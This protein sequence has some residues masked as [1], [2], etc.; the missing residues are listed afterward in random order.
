MK[1]FLFFSMLIVIA[2]VFASCGEHV[3]QFGEWETTKEAT[4]EISGIQE[5]Y[6]SCGAFENKTIEAQ[7]DLYSFKYIGASCGE[8]YTESTCRKCNEVIIEEFTGSGDHTYIQDWWIEQEPDCETPGQAH[9][10]CCYCTE[11]EYKE[12]D[13]LGHLEVVDEAI[14]PTCDRIGLTQGSHCDR[15][16]KTLVQ[17]YTIS[18]LEHT[19]ESVVTEPTYQS[20]GYTTRTCTSCGYS[21][22]VDKTE[23]LKY[24]IIWKDWDETIL[25][26]DSVEYG[27][28][29]TYDTTPAK[30]ST[31]GYIY[32]FNGWDETVT[33][34]TSDA[35]YTAT[36]NSIKLYTITWENWDGTVLETNIVKHGEIPTYNGTTPTKPSTVEYIYEFNGWDE[37]VT[38]ATSDATYKAS[39]YSTTRKYCVTWQNWDGSTLDSYQFAYG[40]MPVYYGFTPTKLSTAE[41]SYEFSGWNNTLTV[42]TGDITYIA[43]YN[44]IKRQYT[45]TWKNWDGT[46]LKIDE[47]ISAGTIPTY[48]GATPTKNSDA[49]TI[50]T[51][52]GEWSSPLEPIYSNTIFTA[53]FAATKGTEINSSNWR[54]YFSINYKYSLKRSTYD[55]KYYSHINVYGQATNINS[56]YEY[57]NV[58]VTVSVTVQFYEIY[59]GGTG[60]RTKTEQFTFTINETGNS[61]FSFD[62]YDVY[63]MASGVNSFSMTLVDI[64]GYAIKK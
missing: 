31:D 39:F 57:V 21:Y 35:T 5:R 16:N 8:H 30:P 1:K 42:V 9:R 6:C 32:E 33:A 59:D 25:R 2:C 47:N 60:Y 27:E 20:E 37:T 19:Y 41:Y 44:A 55:P 53:V 4:C 63:G 10:M 36:Y 13:A 24:T 62:V 46:V 40:E 38:A 15:C 58:K 34:A 56:N 54:N 50:Y 26:I 61:S 49:D 3:H 22:T 29:P 52:E 64:S 11:Y 23:K 45:V 14:E 18:N 51:W 43:T 17:Q 12:I 7:H 28:V 48:N